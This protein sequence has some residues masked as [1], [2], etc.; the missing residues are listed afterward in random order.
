MPMAGDSHFPSTLPLCLMLLATASLQRPPCSPSLVSLCFLLVSSLMV[1]LSCLKVFNGSPGPRGQ[2]Q[3]SQETPNTLGDPAPVRCPASSSP[4][5]P[6]DISM[7][8]ATNDRAS[9]RLLNASGYHW[10][11][12]LLQSTCLYFSYSHRTSIIFPISTYH[13]WSSFPFL[14][15]TIF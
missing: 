8:P 7:V 5:P 11:H 1:S 13:L 9:A 14:K 10:Y 2:V 15:P 3:A 12:S 6:L 4:T